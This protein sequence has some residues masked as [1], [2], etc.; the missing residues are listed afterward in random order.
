M[1]NCTAFSLGDRRLLALIDAALD[2]A[3]ARAGTHLS[4]RLGCTECCHGP[5]PITQLDAWRLRAG[6][7]RLA[8]IDPARADAIVERARAAVAEMRS[9]F[10]GDP[11][12]G[13]LGPDEEAE[14]RFSTAFEQMPCPA[15]DPQSGACELYD[16]RPISCRTFGP[17]VQ[18][19]A[20]PL[21]PCRLCFTAAAPD[22]IDR[23]R[24]VIDPDDEEDALLR[25][26]ERS[27][28]AGETIVAFALATLRISKR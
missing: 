10:P 28:I 16:A 8:Q 18:I 17:P 26:L 27:G 9:T 22:E 4:C 5:F 25:D 13:V 14:E 15:L 21:P 11:E 1:T 3:T 7:E 2:D 12:T 19:G 6:L 20:D 24:V 23:A